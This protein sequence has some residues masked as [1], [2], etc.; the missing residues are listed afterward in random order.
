MRK[1]VRKLKS[2]EEKKKILQPKSQMD[3]EDE[4]YEYS[5]LQLSSEMQAG[6]STSKSFPPS[7]SVI[8]IDDD[9]EIEDGEIVERDVD[10]IEESFSALSQSR[11]IKDLSPLK[12]PIFYEDKNADDGFKPTPIPIYNTIESSNDVICLDNSSP[13]LDDSVVFVSRYESLQK[14]PALLSQN[15]NQLI[16]L[17][18]TPTSNQKKILSPNRIKKLERT[19]KYRE[20][21]ALEKKAKLS[22]PSTSTPIIVKSL[23]EKAKVLQE[24]EKVKTLQGTKKAEKQ[25]RLILIDGSNVAISHAKALQGKKYDEN[26]KFAFSVE[27]KM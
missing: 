7:S 21:K 20:K 8:K 25:K 4:L 26:S 17:S 9:S 23:K 18:N 16:T 1:Y 2:E 11:K 13:E 24:A 27:G 22:E 5:K 19:R 3:Y 12:K 14:P 6:S 10:L 15:I